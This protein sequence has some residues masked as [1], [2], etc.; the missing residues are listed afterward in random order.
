M[1]IP[2]ATLSL[3]LS[4]RDMVGQYHSCR[5]LRLSLHNESYNDGGTDADGADGYGA[6]CMGD[7]DSDDA[8]MLMVLM[9]M[10]LVQMLMVML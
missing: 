6:H 7:A 3:T 2:R 10:M 9:Q 8:V 4:N 5:P 1:R